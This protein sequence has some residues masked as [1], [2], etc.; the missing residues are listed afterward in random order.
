VADRFFCFACGR[1]HRSASDIGRDHR[2]YAIDGGHDTGGIFRDLRE[3]YVQTKGI[4]TALRLLG[5]D[6]TIHPPRFGRGWPSRDAIEK[7]FR[8]RAK[9][10]H[11]D[12]G[13]DPDEFRKIEWAVEVLR[14]YRPP[15]S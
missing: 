12:R 1:D 15:D 9:R 3:F 5:F 14:R 8:E 13:G 10:F 11:P 2:R 6:A 7:A 4:S